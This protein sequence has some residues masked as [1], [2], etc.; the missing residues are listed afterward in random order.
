MEETTFHMHQPNIEGVHTNFHLKRSRNV[1]AAGNFG[2]R[3]PE[4]SGRGETVVIA[5][6]V[7][8]FHEETGASVEF[9]C[10]ENFDRSIGLARA[11]SLG[12]ERRNRAGKASCTDAYRPCPVKS[13]KRG[14]SVL[15]VSKHFP[16][17]GVTQY[18]T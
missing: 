14:L 8:L 16:A 9:V 10:S 13:S 5:T 4:A 18:S 6:K 1:L 15:H 17:L 7:V 12:Q 2:R 3:S 11:I